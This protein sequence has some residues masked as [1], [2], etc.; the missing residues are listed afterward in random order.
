MK[1]ALKWIKEHT[2]LSGCIAAA[3]II[4]GT[5]AIVWRLRNNAEA[6]RKEILSERT[7]QEEQE[8]ASLQETA[9]ESDGKNFLAE[10]SPQ[11][12]V[13]TEHTW[14]ENETKIVWYEDSGETA[15]LTAPFVSE[16]AAETVRE[17][18][19]QP[20]QHGVQETAQTT[21]HT[22]NTGTETAQTQAPSE[23]VQ[24][25]TEAQPAETSGVQT[26][27]PSES[28]TVQSASSYTDGYTL[29]KTDS[30]G[31]EYYTDGTW[32]FSFF[33][34]NGNL[35]VELCYY[36]G[37]ASE[38]TVPSSF[39]GYPV[40]FVGEVFENNQDVHNVII[41]SCVEMMF[42]TFDG[43]HYLDSV[44][45]AGDSKMIYIAEDV[46]FTCYSKGYRSG[47]DEIDDTRPIVYCPAYVEKLISTKA[48]VN[49]IIQ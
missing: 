32:E 24:Q 6:D 26:T 22:Q 11:E 10:T 28:G 13:D 31:F 19:A 27:S 15:I 20:S 33:E 23:K 43:C 14:G 46:F 47:N 45:I 42:G 36:Y 40:V 35:S 39:G 5:G 2:V 48:S 18:A 16:T 7:S 29:V 25:T 9:G 44:T 17:T 4:A 37:N 21:A 8:T 3:V 1:K 30:Y 41:P 38:V 34:Y 12:A 49:I